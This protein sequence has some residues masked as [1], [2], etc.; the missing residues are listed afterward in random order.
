MEVLKDL[1]EALSEK[2]TVTRR[3]FLKGLGAFSATAAIYGCGGGASQSSY[4]TSAPVGAAV[5]SPAN[6]LTID[7]ALTTVMI[8]HPYNCGG[9]CMFK[10]WVKN[11]VMKKIT[12]GMGDVPMGPA[13]DASAENINQ[14]EFRPCARGFAQ[15]KRTYQ[16]DRLKTPMKQTIARGNLKGF[17]S[18]TWEEAYDTIAAAYQTVIA[19][20]AALGYIPA[21]GSLFNYFGTA[22]SFAGSPSTDNMAEAKY[23]LIGSST[24]SNYLADMLNSKFILNVGGNVA[25]SY[26]HQF[27]SN[28]YMLKAKEAGIPIVSMDPIFQDASVTLAT[29][30]P[31]Y[32]V[33]SYINPRIGTDGAVF[34]AMANVIYQKGLHDQN[35][36]QQYCFGFYPGDTVVSQSTMKN[37]ITGAAYAGQTFTTPTGM[38]FV[39]YLNSLMTAHGGYSGVLAWASQIS[40]VPSATIENLAIA[41]ATTKP[42]WIYGIYG[43]GA[44]SVSGYYMVMMAIALAAMTGQSNKIGGGPGYSSLNDPTPV[45]LGA[46][47]NPTTTA[48]TY[49]TISCSCYATAKVITQGTDNRSYAQLRADALALNNIDLGAYQTVRNDAAGHDGRLR[50]EMIASTGNSNRFNQGAGPMSKLML[51]LQQVKF[52]YFTDHFI[53]PSMAPCDIILPQTCHHEYDSFQTKNAVYYFSNKVIP[54]M[55]QTMDSAVISA[56]ILNRLGIKYGIYGPQGTETAK[57]LMAEQWAG[58]TINAQL[59]QI[60]PGATLPSFATFSQQGIFQLPL[61]PSVVSAY[62]AIAALTPGKFPTDT[63]K[64]NF[65][66]PFYFNRDQAL[67]SAYQHADGGYYRS[68]FPPKAMYAPPVE[69]FDPVTGAFLGSY[70]GFK[71]K[72]GQRVTYTLQHSQAHHRRRAHSVYDNVAVLKADYP[73]VATMNITDA[74]ARGIS[75]GDTVYVYNDWGCNKVKVTVT[76][77]VSQGILHIADGEWYRPSDTETYQAWFDQNGD[78]VPEMNVVPVDVGGAP[79]NLQPDRDIGPKEPVVT[80]DNSFHGNFVEVSLT[81]PDK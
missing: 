48:T 9:R 45:N 66:S 4:S 21:V 61:P 31:Q 11:G 37:P 52:M 10:V 19:R 20:K 65:F 2:T 80:F 29:G 8:S 42:S 30:Y 50:I 28:W 69:G 68:A 64:L 43:G 46:T 18:I 38:S 23:G 78:G 24:N 73:A 58:A 47:K 36:I 3:G 33:P 57:Q 40:G 56:E 76:N 27:P 53:T 17:V 77:R 34:A 72:N 22:V 51:S 55:Y 12:S 32:N 49:G 54:A 63:G 7:P 62:G 74:A 71:V 15:V 59:L 79:N 25:V 81:H 1:K 41:Y 67:G 70:Q 26:T 6:N 44:R 5:A 16:P 75:D 39:E 13:A 14:P 60:N 35:F